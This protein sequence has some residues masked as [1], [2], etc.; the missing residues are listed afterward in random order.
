MANQVVATRARV[1]P[2]RGTR[3]RDALVGV[4][5][6][7]VILGTVLYAL[8]GFVFGNLLSSQ[9][10]DLLSFVLPRLSFLGRSLS[11]GHVPL[12]NPFDMAGS[13][14]A[15]DPQSGWLYVSPMLL[16]SLLSPSAAM[17]A[18]VVFNPALAGLGA[19]LLLRM[20]GGG[21]VA[22]TAG[23]LS[24]SMMM[25][26]SII[27]IALPFAGAIAWTTILLAAASGYFRA[28]R[29]SRRT[30]WLL[31]GAFAWGQVAAA[32]MSHGLGMATVLVIAYLA[33]AIAREVRAGRASPRAAT[34]RAIVF[35]AVLPLANVAILAPRIALVG[36]SSLRAGYDAVAAAAGAHRAIVP[37]GVWP[38]W[39]LALGSTP[40]AYAGAAILL[41]IPAA[42]RTR[43]HR[44]LTVALAVASALAY[45]ATWPVV[46]E[47]SW[48]RNLV[49]RIPFGDLYLHNPGRLRYLWLI[50]APLLGA[51]GIQ[52]FIE[53]PI[54][55]GRALGWMGAGLALFLLLP[56]ALGAHPVRF[57]VL[58]IGVVGAV[59]ALGALAA[60]RRVAPILLPGLLALELAGSAA[61]S[62]AYE[63]GTVFLGLEEGEH[64]NLVHQP[65]RWPG[66]PAD[67]YLRRGSIA[68][69][70][71]G[72][73]ERYLTWALPDATFAKGYLW[74]QDAG[75][76]PALANGRG[77][78][79]GAHDVLGYN[80]VQL[81]RYWS[82]MRRTNDSPLYYNAS[83]LSAP[84]PEDIALLGVGYVVV[85]RG[86]DPPVPAQHLVTEGDYE[87]YEVLGKQPRA[88][89]VGT[90]R[91]ENDPAA[92]LD[93]A[94]EPG[95]D[96][97]ATVVLERAPGLD[98]GAAGSSGTAEYLEASPEDVRISVRADGPSILVVRNSWD[99]GWTATV[100]GRPARV[101]VAD[102]MLQG[103]PVP[104][105]RH[106][107]RI[108]YGDRW[109]TRGLL[110]SGAVWVALLVT[111]AATVRRGR[112]C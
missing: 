3:A 8:R 26:T 97:G 85:S 25:S 91:V 104:A 21:R 98:E 14:Y 44:G 109:V 62:Q 68:G 88:S 75:D 76:W 49:L 31:L 93:A 80:P 55:W 66:V 60:G 71:I 52:G 100:D 29:W 12:W 41:A 69:A 35:L 65:L 59:P 81:R 43:S 90:W 110:A 45:A 102:Y 108:V 10:P 4:A 13:P 6:P 22:A 36:R 38:A 89:V 70:L 64:P 16:F 51:I 54:A 27:A 7:L 42:I 40:G 106:E 63:G 37:N 32:H 77:T 28:D 73:Q 20:E 79:F 78:L 87:L 86:F 56:L 83:V 57:S 47:A 50:C 111:W 112:R 19:Y 15:A 24:L 94:L 1:T 17:R 103:V 99:E 105:G 58:S 2:T 82:Y 23:G 30:A 67:D 46:L 72:K 5:G 61:Y 96:T 39:P 107:V 74:S 34:V 84:S 9:H 92:A 18:F 11:H 95:F 48:F 33:A 101:L 53:R